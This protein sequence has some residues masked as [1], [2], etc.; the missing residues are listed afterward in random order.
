MSIHYRTLTEFVSVLFCFIGNFIFWR[1]LIGI[2]QHFWSRKKS[3]VYVLYKI[4]VN[5]III[6]TLC[7]E[8]G[9]A[10][11]INIMRQS[12]DFKSFTIAIKYEYY[13][14]VGSA[15]LLEIS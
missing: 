7:L 12:K 9:I 1:N 10:V 15:I 5:V 6:F 8:A 3:V 11:T 14:I 13:A 4:V 2:E